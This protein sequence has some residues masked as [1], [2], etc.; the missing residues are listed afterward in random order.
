MLKAVLFDAAETLIRPW[1]SYGAVYARVTAAFG[2]RIPAEFF[3][4][5][6]KR[7]FRAVDWPLR[8]DSDTER[9]L[10][11]EVTRKV[12]EA[13]PADLPFHKW[14]GAVYQ[15]FGSQDSWVVE[16]GAA[17]T[18]RALQGLGLRTAVVS[19]WDERLV[20]VL[21]G[22]GLAPHID[23]V[24]VAAQVGWRKPAREI[25]HRAC[26]E[27]GA[28]PS[29]TLHIGDSASEDVAAARAAGLQALLFRPSDPT[30]L[31]RLSHVL[32]SAALVGHTAPSP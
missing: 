30:A 11:L 8:T 14:S 9:R 1:P 18:L 26:L 10:W 22:L 28:A 21:D 2:M 32:H 19:N 25:F 12:Y 27:L 16:P 6:M 13:L 15:A 17:E 7:A 23:R 5:E 3:A 31:R 29:E 20:S 4:E 24:F